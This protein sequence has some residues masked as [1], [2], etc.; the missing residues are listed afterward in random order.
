ME[1][2]SFSNFPFVISPFLDTNLSRQPL[3]YTMESFLLGNQRSP[4][5]Y[6]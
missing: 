2:Y 4:V 3:W 6:L 5:G 1:A